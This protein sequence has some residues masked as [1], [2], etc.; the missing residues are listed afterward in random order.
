MMRIRLAASW[1][2]ISAII[3]LCSDIQVMH[4]ANEALTVGDAI[5]F[6][7]GPVVLLLASAALIKWPYHYIAAIAASV[8]VAYMAWM[9]GSSYWPKSTELNAIAPVQYDWLF[10]VSALIV[11]MSAVAVFAI[12]RIANQ[13]RA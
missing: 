6:F 9:V 7:G 13:G 1:L 12:W 10:V 8:S 11:L 3:W 2:L 4:V 5:W